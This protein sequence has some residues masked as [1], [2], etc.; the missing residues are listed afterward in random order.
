MAT[1][2]QSVWQ[3]YAGLYPRLYELQTLRTM[4]AQVIAVGS[5]L[6]AARLLDAGCGTGLLLRSLAQTGGPYPSYTG[7][8]SSSA[9][10]AHASAVPYPGSVELHRADLDDQR[11]AW[12]LRGPFDR[13]VAVNTLYAVA[14][15]DRT[16]AELAQLAAP[17]ALLV[18]STPS[19]AVRDDPDK[20]MRYVLHQHLELTEAAG[21]DAQAERLRLERDPDVAVIAAINREIANTPH[22][23]FPTEDQVTSWFSHSGWSLRAVTATYAGQNWLIT[24]TR[25]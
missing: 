6:A 14:K 25:G 23:H 7:C 21:G 5:L 19:M 24:A 12:P 1:P 18:A 16:L 20:A 22:F 13:V 3:R 4:F 10:L 2:D 8:D 15:P 9:M 17:G 11:L